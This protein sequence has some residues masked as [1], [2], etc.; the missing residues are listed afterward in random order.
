MANLSKLLRQL[1]CGLMR[2]HRYVPSRE[3]YGYLT[4][5]RCRHRKL[6]PALLT[7]DDR[8]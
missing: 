2:Q 3:R 4:C 6:D 1:M 8:W 5:V 7:L